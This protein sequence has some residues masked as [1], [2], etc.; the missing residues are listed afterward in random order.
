MVGELNELHS[1]FL[2]CHKLTNYGKLI[3]LSLLFEPFCVF[4]IFSFSQLQNNANILQQL[5]LSLRGVLSL[6]FSPSQFSLSTTP[7]PLKYLITCNGN[8]PLITPCKLAILLSTIKMKI[9]ITSLK[10]VLWCSARKGKK[11]FLSRVH[12]INPWKKKMGWG[13]L[14]CACGQLSD[15]WFSLSVC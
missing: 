9:P 4:L 13:Q 6:L 12:I 1:E 11:C 15:M 7:L 8:I 3:A 2:F 10:K 14:Y 5:R